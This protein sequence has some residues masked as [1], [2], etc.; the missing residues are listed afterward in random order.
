MRRLRRARQLLW[1]PHQG[2]WNWALL[3]RV[4]RLPGGR[5][6]ARLVVLAD[7]ALLVA[8]TLPRLGRN[9]SLP[10]R[11]LYLDCGVH[12]EGLQIREVWRWL[13][14]KTEL[15]IVGFE[16]SPEHIEDARR[17]LADV[18]CRLEQLALVGP[19]HAG[20]SIRLYRDGADGKGDSLFQARGTEYF[21]VPCA[22]LS[23]LLPAA[24]ADEAIVLRMNIEGAEEFVIADL[25]EAG[26]T[27]RIAGY[28]GMWDDLSKI[29]PERDRAFRDEL[30]SL[31]VVTMTFNDRDFA[32][33]ARLWAIRQRMLADLAGATN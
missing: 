2:L 14:R 19:D 4:E 28:F 12:K 9:R 6:L 30:A 8:R 16:A 25:A 1:H 17:N 18:P 32:S 13:G 26:A 15:E 21:D 10:R 5:Y 3:R 23:T 27:K 22:R 33:R 7:T 11:V 20:A 24:G 31:G 29:D